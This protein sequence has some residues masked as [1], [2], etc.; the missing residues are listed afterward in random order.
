[1]RTPT[2]L[3][4]FIGAG[5]IGGGIALHATNAAAERRLILG[6]AQN[7]SCSSCQGNAAG[8]LYY[9]EAIGFLNSLP[10][11]EVSS[12][13]VGGT[14]TTACA[15]ANQHRARLTTRDGFGNLV[16]PV[17]AESAIQTTWTSESAL[18]SYAAPA[19]ANCPGGA[20]LFLVSQGAN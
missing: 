2:I 14:S 11:C 1:M 5:L 15:L 7:T 8:Q 12:V 17:L 9:A 3:R 20:A 13:A 16:L 6:V 10:V 18:V 4:W 19:S